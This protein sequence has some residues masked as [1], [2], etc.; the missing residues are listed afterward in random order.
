MNKAEAKK[1]AAKSA[2][3]KVAPTIY[4]EMKWATQTV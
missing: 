1:V 2:L 4:A 3:E